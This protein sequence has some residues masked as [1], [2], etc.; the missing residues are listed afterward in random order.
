MQ[1]AR[2]AAAA[3]ARV[4]VEVERSIRL[5]ACLAAQHLAL[6]QVAGRQRFI[7]HVVLGVL[8][9]FTAAL[10][11]RANPFAAV[12]RN[13][14]PAAQGRVE[15]DFIVLHV[16]EECFAVGETEGDLVRHGR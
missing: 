10:A 14:D 4:E 9:G 3:E 12:Q 5:H 13:L 2:A 16:A 8:P 6:S 1:A 7:V 15:Q 11:G